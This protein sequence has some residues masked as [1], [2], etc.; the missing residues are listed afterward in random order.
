MPN[1]DPGLAEP[2]DEFT[3][4][5]FLRSDVLASPNDDVFDS[6]GNEKIA[7]SHI[8]AIAGIEPSVVEQLAGLP[9]ILK[10]SRC[11]R[12]TAKFDSPLLPFPN[13]A[14]G[15]I[16]NANLMIGNR[17][18]TSDKFDGVEVVWSR[19]LRKSA[20][21]QGLPVDPIDNWQPSGWGQG[22]CDSIFRK[23]VDRSHR[24]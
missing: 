22:H 24:V 11:R 9:W 19:W 21:A 14:T 18:A 20:T 3:A 7:A 12:R 15:A 23:P 17:M 6:P 8:P 16:D 2:R 10:I 5:S 4:S 1:R 13:L